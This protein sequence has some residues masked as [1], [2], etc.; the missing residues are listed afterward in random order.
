MTTGPSTARPRHLVQC[1]QCHRP[2]LVEGEG[3]TCSLCGALLPTDGPPRAHERLVYEKGSH[4][5]ASLGWGAG[6][7]LSAEKLTWVPRRGAPVAIELAQLASVRL[8]RRSVYESL[9]LTAIFGALAWV[10]P[11]TAPKVLLACV[12]VLSVVAMLTQKRWWLELEDH[13]RRRAALGL[14][15]GAP[16]SPLAQR[17][18]S[19]WATLREELGGRG[20]S[21]GP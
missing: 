16:Q 21:C 2:Q 19:A 17:I 13:Q 8:V 5:E 12:A 9:V 20:I 1:A 10:T 3:G 11:W 18:M 15:I 7:V 14:G 4:V 6:L